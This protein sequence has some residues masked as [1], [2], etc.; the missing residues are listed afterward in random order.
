M[1]AEDPRPQEQQRYVQPVVGTQKPYQYSATPVASRQC[2][3]HQTG[4]EGL[5]CGIQAPAVNVQAARTTP[6][7]QQEQWLIDARPD[8][9]GIP[10][11][12]VPAIP[13]KQG[14][15]G[16]AIDRK[17][18]M[19]VPRDVWRLRSLP[20]YKRYIAYRQMAE[21]GR[22]MSEYD[23]TSKEN[24][25]L[26]KRITTFEASLIEAE[27]EFANRLKQDTAETRARWDRI[28]AAQAVTHPLD[29]VSVPPHPGELEDFT[30]HEVTGMYKCNH[31]FETGAC[32]TE[33]VT[34]ER[35]RASI[36]RD[37]SAWKR[38]VEKLVKKGDLNK[39]HITWKTELSSNKKEDPKTKNAEKGRP[40][41]EKK[42]DATAKKEA[43]KEQR[44][45]WRE[46]P[47]DEI[48][49]EG[50]PGSIVAPNPLEQDDL[51][52]S[53]VESKRS[54]EEQAAAA[55]SAR[56]EK[57]AKDLKKYG[58]DLK[59]CK[60]MEDMKKWPTW[61]RFNEYWAAKR[62]EVQ[63]LQL[64]PEQHTLLQGWEPSA[65]PDKNPAFVKKLAEDTVHVDAGESAEV[66]D[67]NLDELFE[68]G[69]EN[70]EQDDPV[71]DD[72]FEDGSLEL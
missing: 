53:K 30:P 35:K 25:S 37:K 50:A 48:D 20:S 19:L 18:E 70:V 32:C 13:A 12:I 61:S 9:Q 64:S 8:L 52:T 49:A 6:R 42:A 36:S 10:V 22:Q 60:R 1:P 4:V 23:Q 43:R 63:Q 14:T 71:L 62:L 27:V 24:Q 3:S 31:Q 47:H 15:I 40:Q 21:L 28:V 5:H 17:D 39:S 16:T 69:N 59:R 68:D 67:S 46:Q 72:L 38:K 41:S 29:K 45:K 11:T 54:S 57:I 65:I 44:K 58:W 66:D 56:Q 7:T 34:K 2:A 55:E 26:W 33:G 51:F